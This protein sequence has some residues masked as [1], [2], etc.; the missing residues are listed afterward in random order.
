MPPN[1]KS[2]ALFTSSLELENLKIPLQAKFLPLT[3]PREIVQQ[4]EKKQKCV[5]QELRPD[6]KTEKPT[7]AVSYWDWPSATVE[8]EK[9]DAINELFS[10]SHFESNLI[11]DSIR[12]EKYSTVQVHLTKSKD[13]KE[14]IEEQESYWGWSNEDVEAIKSEIDGQDEPT[15]LAVD[16]QED[17]WTWLENEATDDA[18]R[19]SSPSHRLHNIVAESRKKYIRRHIHLSEPCPRADESAI[20]DHYWHLSEFRS[21]NANNITN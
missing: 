13:K 19:Q 10:I 11:A 5:H 6:P 1:R 2:P 4:H 20:S 12:R 21:I 7:P 17:Y 8:E 18:C 14:Q 3:D 9:L 16:R 15:P